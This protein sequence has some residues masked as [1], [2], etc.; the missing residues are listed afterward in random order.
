MA[1]CLAC[2]AVLGGLVLARRTPQLPFWTL[3]VPLGCAVFGFRRLRLFGLYSLI[4]FGFLLGWWR[5]GLLMQQVRLNREYANRKVTVQGVASID[6]IYD[7][8]KQMAF[9]VQHAVIVAPDAVQGE[10]LAGTI[11]VAGFGLSGVNRGD[12]VTATGKLY[13]TRG[14]NAYSIS[15]ATLSVSP[16]PPNKLE[17][18]RHGFTAGMYSS[19]PE[20]LAPFAMGLL[21]GQRSLIPPDLYGK[22][23]AVGLTHIVAVSGYNLT[24]I[25]G[26]VRRIM[27]KRSKFQSLVVSLAL[28]G[29]FLAVT[30]LS[31]SIV[32]AAMISSLSL[33]AAYYGRTIRPMVLILFTAAVTALW[34]PFYVWGDIGWY[35]SFL[36]FFGIL[37]LAPLFTR[38]FFGAHEPGVAVSAVIETSAAELLTLPFIMFIFGR[39]SLIGL[40][41]NLLVVPLVPLAMLASFVAALAGMWVPA[42][43]GWFALPARLSLTYMLDTILLLARIPH[44]LVSLTLGV[45]A[46]ILLYASILSI[47]VV[48]WRRQ[49]K[50]GKITDRT[51]AKQGLPT[52]ERTLQM[53]ND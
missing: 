37:V 12:F 22:L 33:L 4:A 5:G 16:G 9:A 39:L 46:M 35:L 6:G 24:I 49:P 20:P 11:A 23:T 1:I 18:F 13:P 31:A 45:W 10:K 21:I 25:I 50:T 51:R 53:V 27:G 14:A 29:L 38:R 3:L 40:V 36:A 47:I 26:A 52:Y 34:N 8:H 43:S 7:D 2:V 15:F 44:E 32:R 41:A 28:I 42:I 17:D 48:L 30:G 19:L